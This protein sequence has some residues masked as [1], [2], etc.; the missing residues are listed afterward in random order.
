MWCEVGVQLYSFAWRYPSISAPF[1]EKTVLFPIGR[2]WHPCRKSV[3]HKCK[4][5]FLDSQFYPINLYTYPYA[6]IT[7][8]SLLKLY[9]KFGASQVVLAIKNLPANAGDIRDA[10]SISGSG[11]SP[12]TGYGNPL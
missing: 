7:Q 8:S 2:S 12:G 4:G 5:L 10:D 9:R 11:R 6:D 1:V 3:N